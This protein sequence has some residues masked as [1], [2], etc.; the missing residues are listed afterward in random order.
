MY[1]NVVPLGKDVLLNAYLVRSMSSGELVKGKGGGVALSYGSIVSLRTEHTR[2]SSPGRVILCVYRVKMCEF[3]L[4][5]FFLH[6]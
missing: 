2:R 6:L 3:Q 1:S 4:S 5:L